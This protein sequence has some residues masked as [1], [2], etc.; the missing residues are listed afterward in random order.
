MKAVSTVV[1]LSALVLA[2]IGATHIVQAPKQE[3]P[4]AVVV[5]EISSLERARQA[6]FD[7]DMPIGA[8]SAVLVGR[9]QLEDGEYLYRALTAHHVIAEYLADIK[10][11]GEDANLDA[12]LTFQPEFHGEQLQIDVV[13]DALDWLVPSGDWASF[14]F[15]HET[16]LE[17]ADVATREEF[18]AIGAFEHIYFVA[19]FGPYA[20]QCRH[21]II[22]TTHNTGVYVDAQLTSDLPWNQQPQDFFR[23]SMPI[24]Y[25]DSG[26]PIFNKDGKLIGLGNAFTVGHSMTQQVTHSGVAVK[27]HI[28]REA[29][30][31]HEDFFKMEN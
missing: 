16:R 30:A 5:K 23:F 2:G 14:T 7:L 22:S 20:Q 19:S 25:G 3:P 26:G 12:M 4:A 17:C 18:R 1:V 28:I 15:R 11:N 29:V 6:S 31:D 27:A 9:V 13:I 21:G 24:W 8:G 10:L